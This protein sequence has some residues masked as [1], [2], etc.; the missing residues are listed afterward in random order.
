MDASKNVVNGM[1]SLDTLPN[2]WMWVRN[3]LLDQFL[4]FL[5]ALGD[6]NSRPGVSEIFSGVSGKP[7]I[8]GFLSGYFGVHSGR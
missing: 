6:I 3:F 1:I 4:N 8:S 5:T 7:G 2:S